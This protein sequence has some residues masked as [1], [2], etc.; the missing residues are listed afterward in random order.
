MNSMVQKTI[1]FLMFFTIQCSMQNMLAANEKI[2]ISAHALSAEENLSIF[3]RNLHE[4][5][6]FPV[7]ISIKNNT[8]KA[9]RISPANILIEGAELLTPKRLESKIKFSTLSA[10]FL[11][12]AV[13]PV[14]LLGMYE[15]VHLKKIEPII[16]QNSIS[17]ETTTIEPG[18]TLE[19]ML[20][21]QF[22]YP[23]YIDGKS[24]KFVTPKALDITIKLKSIKYLLFQSGIVLKVN[25]VIP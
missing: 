10:F 19:T 17:D 3:Y 5:R 1:F 8:D 12:I 25:V 24:Q 4:D 15:M 21:A 9:Q 7:K 6:I 11:I 2:S 16:D 20:F 14:G 13:F 22:D 23:E 18:Q